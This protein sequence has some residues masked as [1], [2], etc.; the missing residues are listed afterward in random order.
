MRKPAYPYRKCG[1]STYEFVSIGNNNIVKRVEFIQ[2]EIKN[3]VALGFGDLLADGTLSD[4]ANSNNG[5][6]GM[7]MSTIIKI[8]E[9][10]T[11]SRPNIKIFFE[12][13]TEGRTRLYGRIL[14]NYY[15]EFSNHFKITGFRIDSLV[16][17][18]FNPNELY[19]YNLYFIQRIT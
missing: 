16:E 10:Y 7:V 2:T 13:S 11:L 8:I 1:E 5:D 15:H 19:I 3:I 9:E 14:K 4:Q 6:M 12:G 18:P 17:E